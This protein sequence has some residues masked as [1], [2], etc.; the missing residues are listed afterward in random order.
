LR[1]GSPGDWPAQQ[2]GGWTPPRKDAMEGLTGPSGVARATSNG[3]EP[4]RPAAPSVPLRPC[5]ITF[6]GLYASEAPRIE[7]RAWLDR[8]GALTAPMTGGHVAIESIVQSRKE[9]RYRVHMELT[10]PA[11]V[12]IVELDHP[13]NGRSRGP[14]RRNPQRVSGRA[15]RVGA[16]LP[17]SPRSKRGSGQRTGRGGTP[18]HRYRVTAM[19][20]R[21]EGV[22]P[23]PI[24]DRSPDQPRNGPRRCRPSR[25]GGSCR[26]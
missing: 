15:T 26:Q 8:L 14:L 1:S 13:S 17:G 21:A 3:I 12:V 10:M 24:S 2:P 4:S 5:R 22:A 20:P 7:V 11:G 18:R 23:H 6:D 9:R 19:P 16:L 25:D